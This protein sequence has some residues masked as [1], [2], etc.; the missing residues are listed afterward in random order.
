[1]TK[2]RLWSKPNVLN[3][4]GTRELQPLLQEKLALQQDVMATASGVS[5]SSQHPYLL[6]LVTYLILLELQPKKLHFMNIFMQSNMHI[7]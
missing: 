1:M 4:C 6:G 7:Y 5:I 2:V 3:G